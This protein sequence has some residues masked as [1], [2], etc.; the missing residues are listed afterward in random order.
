MNGRRAFA[1]VC[2]VGLVWP[3]SAAAVRSHVKTLSFGKRPDTVAVDGRTNVIY[4]GSARENT[5]TVL[6]GLGEIQRPAGG[7]I[8]DM[9]VDSTTGRIYD[10]DGKLNRL[11]VRTRTEVLAEIAISARPVAVAVDESARRVYVTSAEESSVLD[12]E[13]PDLPKGPKMPQT[14][15]ANRLTVIDAGTNAVLHRINLTQR[16]GDVVAGKVDQ[17]TRA[18][19]VANPD[20]DTVTRIRDLVTPVVEATIPVGDVPQALAIALDPDPYVADSQRR[21]LFVANT[22]SGSISVVDTKTNAVVGSINLGLDARPVA[23]AADDVLLRIHVVD[24]SGSVRALERTPGSL[25]YSAGETIA[26]GGNPRAIALNRASHRVY[27]TNP[28]ANNVAFI[29]RFDPRVHGFHFVNRFQ[30]NIFVDLPLGLGRWDIAHHR[31]GLC[32]G[33]AFAASDTYYTGGVTPPD[34]SPPNQGSRLRGHL[35][36]RQLDT[37]LPHGAHVVFRF[38]EWMK[39]PI[40]NRLGVKGTKTR[41]FDEFHE[42]I[43]PRLDRRELV[44]LGVVKVA[45]PLPAQTVERVWENHQVV[46]IGYFA[47]P[48]TNEWVIELYDPNYPYPNDSD[49]ITYFHTRRRVQTYDKLGDQRVPGDRYRG[50]FAILNYDVEHP[51]WVPQVLPSA[52]GPLEPPPIPRDPRG[53][54][55]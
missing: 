44:Q 9:A 26:L 40:D 10:L 27:V 5:I 7:L 19:Y 32:G 13:L 2:A 16:P 43:R 22:Q 8:V 50:F 21:H 36:E 35:Y 6:N 49:G 20:D 4:V 12:P 48:T 39:L 18:V 53:P 31:Y 47:H 15:S 28:S 45:S 3:G 30:A 46:A 17:N 33:M 24:A 23:L 51:Y 1:V 25:G 29:R 38:L 37:L 34:E 41:S 11:F 42:K 55:P 52:P 14:G 54:K